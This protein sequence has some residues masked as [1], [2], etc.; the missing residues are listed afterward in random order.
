MVITY[1]IASLYGRLLGDARQMSE[2]RSIVGS[3]LSQYA[4]QDAKHTSLR[5]AG[6]A[7]NYLL[8]NSY[9][10]GQHSQPLVE[11]DKNSKE[12]VLMLHSLFVKIHIL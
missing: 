5:V 3:L 4:D 12:S 8:H 7:Q 2:V 6:I 11:L 10:F 9:L 1:R